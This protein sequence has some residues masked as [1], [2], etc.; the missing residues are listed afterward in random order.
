MGAM[1]AEKRAASSS[2]SE[3]GLSDDTIVNVALASEAEAAAHAAHMQHV[4][5]FFAEPL[6]VLMSRVCK[7]WREA[8]AAFGFDTLW[9]AAFALRFAEQL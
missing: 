8:L 3:W 6:F 2:T 9:R 4:W 5:P 1:L 7:S